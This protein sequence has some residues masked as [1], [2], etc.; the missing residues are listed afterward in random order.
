MLLMTTKIIVVALAGALA[1]MLA[2]RGVAVFHDGLRP[3][4]PEFIEGRISRK[5][6]IAVAFALS[7]GLIIG[8]GIPF[9]VMYPILL[10]H[11][12]FLGTDVI[13][14]AM[15]GRPGL[16]LREPESLI[17]LAASGV[18]GAVYGILLTLG[19]KGFADL[20]TKLPINFFDAMGKIGD[21]V[22]FSF[23]AFPALAVSFQY[24]IKPGLITFALTL[25]G[26]QLGLIAGMAKPDGLALAVGMVVLV[27]WALRE[28]KDT[29][30]ITAEG[31]FSIRADRIRRSLPFIALMGAIYGLA[32]NLHIMMEGPQSLVALGKNDVS[33]ALG[34]TIARALSFI[35]LKGTTA[36]AT[37]VFVTDGFGFTATAGLLA[38]SP[39]LAFIL[40]AIVMS[41][42]ALSLTLVGS[43]LDR[44]PGVRKAADNIRT[45]MTRVLEVALL[46]GGGIACDAIMPGLGFLVMAGAYVLNE[47]AGVPITRMAVGPVTAIAAGLLAN[48]LVIMGLLPLPTK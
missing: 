36:L 45:A 40:G 35:P 39:I 7:F 6:L 8:F 23:A 24:G 42:E 41:V 12:L 44:F 2:N 1:S 22:V 20:M 21:P 31:F 48:L 34:I 46:I 33:G 27:L 32:C 29:T 9:S 11:C 47:A 5:E 14:V 30:G 28:P 37:G 43:L 13:G 17:G 26:R 19:L 38:P 18:A 10:V 25:V 16:S 4:M 15:P 3:I